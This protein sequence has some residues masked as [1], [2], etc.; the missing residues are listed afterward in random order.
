MTVLPNDVIRVSARFKH[1]TAGDVVNVFHWFAVS[2][3]TGDSDEDVMDGID[4]KLSDAYANV[5]ANMTSM[6][7]PY[8]IRYDLVE[9][10]AGREVVT[11]ALGTRTWTLTTPPS[12]AGDGLPTM[13]AAIINFRTPEPKTFG[14]KYLG[15]MVEATQNNGVMSG[16]ILTNLAAFATELLTDIALTDLSLRAGTMSYKA[17]SSTHF[18]QFLSAVVN[19]VLGTQRRRRLNRGS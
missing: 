13:D 15:G 7:D 5:A 11:R 17:I 6:L 14:R 3:S 9:W 1:D 10:S 19:A 12:A 18:V 2:G 4:T 8:D 16:A